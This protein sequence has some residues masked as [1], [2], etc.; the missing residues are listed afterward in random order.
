MTFLNG[1]DQTLNGK[2]NAH[3]PCFSN[4]WPLKALNNIAQQSP[5][6]AHIHTPTAEAA[7]QGDSS[8]SGAVRVRC[9]AQGHL[10]TQQQEL[11]GVGDQTSILPVTSQPALPPR[12]HAAL[13][14][15]SSVRKARASALIFPRRQHKLCLSRPAARAA[16]SPRHTTSQT[17]ASRPTLP[18]PSATSENCLASGRTTTW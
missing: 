4:Q 8:W 3:I 11:T 16:T 7:M 14:A 9:L 13:S 15:A 2:W 17:S 10:D 18:W 12:P 1:T 5:I 6:H